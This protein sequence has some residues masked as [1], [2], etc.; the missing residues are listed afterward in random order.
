MNEIVVEKSGTQVR[1]DVTIRIRGNKGHLCLVEAINLKP[2]WFISTLIVRNGLR[3]YWFGTGGF[4]DP[5]QRNIQKVY[6]IDVDM[7]NL[8]VFTSESE[9]RNMK[10][11]NAR[12]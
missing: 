2:Q 4:T 9:N 11:C 3:R 10:R 7:V 12:T 1:P 6:A 5:S 8:L